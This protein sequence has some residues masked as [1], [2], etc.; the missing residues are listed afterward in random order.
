MPSWSLE[1]PRPGTTVRA[2][3]FDR[4]AAEGIGTG[5]YMGGRSGCTT[6]SSEA[7]VAEFAAVALRL[8]LGTPS[9]DDPAVRLHRHTQGVFI[10]PPDRSVQKVLAGTAGSSGPTWS[11][12]SWLPGGLSPRPASMLITGELKH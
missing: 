12:P 11:S 4:Q 2:G 6:F 7:G 8:Y 3:G 9:V 10:S 5:L 1:A